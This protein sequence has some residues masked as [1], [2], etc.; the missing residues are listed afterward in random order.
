MGRG[1][2]GG[3]GMFVCHNEGGNQEFTLTKTEKEFRHQDFCL[4]VKY[5]T[6][7]SGTAVKFARCSGKA[8]QK[9]VYQNS[10]LRP[11]VDTS[12]CL[13]SNDFMKNPGNDIIVSKCEG[14]SSK[15][16]YWKFELRNT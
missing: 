6:P 14:R 7:S 3:P 4:E 16:Q 13:D 5:S 9:W 10:S 12:L 2:G 8:R 15:R 11:E 1:A